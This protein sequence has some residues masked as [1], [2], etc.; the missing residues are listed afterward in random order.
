M[1]INAKI[2][3]AVLLP[4]VMPIMYVDRLSAQVL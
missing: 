2:W 4:P 1:I 3:I